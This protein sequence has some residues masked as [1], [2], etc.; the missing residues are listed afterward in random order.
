MVLLLTVLFLMGLGGLTGVVFKDEHGP[1]AFPIEVEVAEIS[2][3]EDTVV[4][5]E[6]PALAEL[7]A[8]A[9]VK[10][11]QNVYK[12]CRICHTSEQG[13]KNMIGPNLWDVVGRAKGG[14]DG[15][16]YSKAMMASGGDWTFES[17]YAYLKKPS[18]YMPRTKMKFAGLRKASDRAAVIALMRSFS[19]AP[20]DLPAVVVTPE[21]EAP[22]AEAPE[23]ETPG[24]DVQE[25]GSVE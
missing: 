1:N 23:A 16:A 12:K 22:E 14:L 3:A 15:Y 21:V 2:T 13:G 4:A 11:G 25:E 9:T 7:L 8:L 20:V 18:D 6:G 19:D 24:T 10:K 17:L 5:V